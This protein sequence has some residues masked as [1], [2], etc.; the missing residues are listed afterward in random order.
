MKADALHK[1]DAF[2]GRHITVS[3]PRGRRYRSV[4]TLP[5]ASARYC[6]GLTA[7]ALIS[8]RVSRT[9]G[10]K[11][12]AAVWCFDHYAHDAG[13]DDHSCEQPARMARVDGWKVETSN[14]SRNSRIEIRNTVFLSTDFSHHNS[15]NCASGE[16][17]TSVLQDDISSVRSYERGFNGV[18]QALWDA[19]ANPCGALVLRH[20][21]RVFPSRSW[22]IAGYWLSSWDD[23]AIFSP[24]GMSCHADRTARGAVSYAIVRLIPGSRLERW[25][26]TLDYPLTAL[27]NLQLMRE[28]L[29]SGDLQGKIPQW[30]PLWDME[31]SAF[32]TVTLGT[33]PISC[34]GCWQ[35]EEAESLADCVLVAM[36][37]V[38]ENGW[39]DAP[40]LVRAPEAA[41]IE[42]TLIEPT[43]WWRRKDHCIKGKGC[44][45]P[46]GAT[47]LPAVWDDISEV[48]EFERGLAE[49]SGLKSYAG[50]WL[51]Y[52]SVV[53]RFHL[54]KDQ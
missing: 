33:D 53:W 4:L 54:G 47:Y 14:I 20:A 30:S 41:S 40:P 16:S 52:D 22:V 23:D 28:G 5:H 37:R 51:V 25:R 43:R 1:A 9:L 18:G 45:L 29:V 8:E 49:K 11:P 46:G 34:W 24:A 7:L 27:Q 48:K 12:H 38:L 10:R 2:L 3:A 17:E 31:G 15:G 36:R 32:V 13:D 26:R 42:V 50:E 39:N 44:R 21:R 6:G 35:D 19:C